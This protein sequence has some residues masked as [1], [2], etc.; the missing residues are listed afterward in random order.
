MQFGKFEEIQE[1]GYNAAIQM[2]AQ[3]EQDGKLPSV[4]LLDTPRT[5]RRKGLSIRRNSI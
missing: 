1:V 4:H 5:G 3:F 2:I